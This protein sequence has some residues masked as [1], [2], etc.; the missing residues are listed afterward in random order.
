MEFFQMMTVEMSKRV[1]VH[2]LNEHD[3]KLCL[4]GISVM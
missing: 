1:E 2:L 4:D 3:L